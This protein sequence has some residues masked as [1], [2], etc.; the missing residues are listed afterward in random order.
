MN[1]EFKFLNQQLQS[2]LNQQLPEIY[3]TVFCL[4]GGEVK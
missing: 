1:L 3:K 4:K 2:C